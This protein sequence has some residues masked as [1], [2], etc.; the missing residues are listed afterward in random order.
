[1]VMREIT[2]MAVIMEMVAIVEMVVVMEPVVVTEAVIVM[3]AEVVTEGV[4][5]EDKR[6]SLMIPIEKMF[7]RWNNSTVTQEVNKICD[8]ILI[9]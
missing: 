2:G 4:I 6:R 1:M 3:E 9:K 5:I 7:K 8:V